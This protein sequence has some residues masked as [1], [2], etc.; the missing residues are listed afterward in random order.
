MFGKKSQ[1]QSSDLTSPAA[2]KRSQKAYDRIA[3]GK[4]R[5]AAAELDAAHGRGSKRG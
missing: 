4:T 5:N 3:S 1:Q 2:V